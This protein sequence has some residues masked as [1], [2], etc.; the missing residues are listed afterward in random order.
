MKTSR[1]LSLLVMAFLASSTGLRLGAQESLQIE[2]KSRGPQVELRWLSKLRLPLG[3]SVAQYEIQRSDDLIQWQTVGR[4]VLGRMGVSDELLRTNVAIVSPQS[5]YRLAGRVQTGATQ[6]TGAEV[7]GYGTAFAQEIQRLGQISPA[8]FGLRYAPDAAYLPAITWDPTT[9]QYWPDWQ[10]ARLNGAELAVFTNYGFVVSE[11]LGSKSFADLFYR[12]HSADLPVFVST[13]AIL[14]AWHFSYQEMLKELEQSYLFTQIDRILTALSSQ[15]SPCW[16]AYGGGVLKNSILDADYFITVARSLLSGQ[17]LPSLLG[18]DTR[19]SATLTAIQAQTY[20][21][22]FNLFGATRAVDFSQF[23]VRGHYTSSEK[24]K[25]YFQAMM[26]LGRTDLRVAGVSD[27][28]RP[29]ALRELGTAIVLLHLL[30]QAGQ[31]DNWQSFDECLQAFVGCTDS[32]TFA[33][34]NQ[35]LAAARL[36]GPADIPTLAVLEQFQQALEQG[37]VGAQQIRGDVFFSPFGPEQVKLPVS[38]TFAGQKFVLD[39]WVL[40]KVVYD[41]ILWDT[42]GV[43]TEADKVVRRIPS[44]LDVAFAVFGNNQA[45]PEIIARI[46]NLNGRRFRDRLFYQHNLA[47]ARNVVDRQAPGSWTNNIYSHWLATLRELSAPTTD[48]RYPE[49]M[50]TRP[51][52]MKTLNTQLASW[53]QLRHDTILYAKQ[54]YTAGTVCSYPYGYVEP[55]LSFWQRLALM[56]RSAAALIETMPYAGPCQI[57]LDTSWPS[58]RTIDLATVKANQ[59]RFLRQFAATVDQLAGIAEK[60]LAHQPMVATEVQFIRNLIEYNSGSGVRRYTGW[61]PALFYKNLLQAFDF[62]M[63]A[64]ADKWDPLVADV[65]T[66]VP[67]ILHGDPGYILHEA[68]GNVHFLLL[69]VD[70]DGD[71]MVYGGPVLSH[72]EFDLPFDTRQSDPEWQNQLSQGNHP[73]QP[74]WTR[75]YLVPGAFR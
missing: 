52:A 8:E 75:S 39:S 38:F 24:M 72:Y 1:S 5:Y 69:A 35:L 70:C 25:R 12:I 71:R 4:P 58:T 47:A 62:D 27:A 65:H 9:A 36:P 28:E 43:L 2:I 63:G 50:R 16:Q 14:Q 23:K 19:V 60:E 56:A 21:P 40:A 46:T 29:Q 6:A 37:Q 55:R 49:C 30:Q 42:D 68:V 17:R 41:E 51:W 67:S 48:S 44:G 66:D 11:R 26:W 15:I 64:G 54:S 22:L 32:M 13:D 53:T 34:L 31:F 59:T 73:P 3:N 7:F 20:D 74:D 61:Y 33:Q 18:Q 57:D 45:V 10:T